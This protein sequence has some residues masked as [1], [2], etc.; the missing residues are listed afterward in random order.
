MRGQNPILSASSSMTEE[1][2]SKE[3][4]RAVRDE[5]E[6]EMR[7][8]W[9]SLWWSGIAAG[10][11]MSA[12]VLGPAVMHEAGASALVSDLGYCLGFLIVVLGRL[13]LFTENTIT[14]VL[15][16]LSRPSAGALWRMTRLWGVVFVANLVGAALAAAVLTG[17]GMLDEPQRVALYEISLHATQ[18]PPAAA[19]QRAVPAG[20]FIAALVWVARGTPEARFWVISGITYLVA[21]G[22]FAH[23][24]A[25]S[26]EAFVVVF[27]DGPAQLLSAAGFILPAL[28]GNILGGAGLFA[29]LTYAQVRGELGR[30]SR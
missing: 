2:S 10:V 13:Q 27:Q 20:F 15:P 8:P 6:R 3:L 14:T 12:S 5:G 25:G 18:I 21:L 11:C 30:H 29:M 16:V 17:S 19:F 28:A 22:N 4:Y 23:V 24:V 7:R 1:D 26:V 9:A